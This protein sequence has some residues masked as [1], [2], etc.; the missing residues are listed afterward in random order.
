MMMR[1]SLVMMMMTR[2]KNGT[3]FH[4]TQNAYYHLQN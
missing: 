3:L 2:E 4:T 1:M